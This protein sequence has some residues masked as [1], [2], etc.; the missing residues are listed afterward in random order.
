MKENFDKVKELKDKLFAKRENGGKVLSDEEITKSENFSVDYK[1]FLNKSK[2][3]RETVQYALEKA[4]KFGFEQF[5]KTKAYNPGDKIY[6]TNR[7][8]NIILCVVG[9]NKL[10]YGANFAVAHIDAPRID[11]KPNP[12]VENNEIAMFKTHYYGGI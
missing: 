11:L 3:E 9:K 6:F 10:K 5:D 8:K 1:D 2:T 4:K 12:I 7:E